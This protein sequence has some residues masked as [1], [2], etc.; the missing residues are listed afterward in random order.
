MLTRKHMKHKAASA[1][2]AVFEGLL[3]IL[4]V[5]VGM[6]WI[7]CASATEWPQYRGANHDAV[8]PDRIL[9]QWTGTATNAVW[10]VTLGAGYSSFA[11]AQG[12][13][14]TQVY[15]SSRETCIALSL[16][17]GTELWARNVDSGASYGGYTGPRST[18]T[19]VSNSV[20]VLTSNLKLLRLNVTN[21]LVV[22]SN[23]LVSAYGAQNISWASSASP[24]VENGLIFVNLS[25]GNRSL[26]AFRTSD[27]SL[28]WRGENDT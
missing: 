21:G 5:A 16:T 13:A 4:M 14:V 7:H 12:K 3:A 9:K 27:G 17:N 20:Y 26:A 8:S 25:T 11:A 1:V 22:W 15:R 2:S 10:R 19:V 18:P 23:N 24:L 28:A 6:G